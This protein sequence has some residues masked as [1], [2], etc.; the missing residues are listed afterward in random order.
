MGI[1]LYAMSIAA[2]REAFV[3][4]AIMFVYFIVMLRERWQLVGMAGILGVLASLNGNLLHR[5]TTSSESDG[6]GRLD[7]WRAAGAAFRGHWLI[8]SG[9][10]SF[11]TA[12]NDVYLKVFQQYDMGWSRA[13]HNM[14]LQNS[15][16]YGTIG[17]LLMVTAVITTFC[18]LRF[19]DKRS[20]L[21]GTRIAVGGALLGLCVAGFFVDLTTGKIFWL[22]LSLVALVRARGTLLPFRRENAPVCT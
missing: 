12:Y 13:A 16:E 18:S 2:S 3:A 1:L 11:A 7:I 19:I 8:G 5:F 4:V 17:A 14:L 15:V 6:S 22:T 9:S 21:Y 20:P 10:G